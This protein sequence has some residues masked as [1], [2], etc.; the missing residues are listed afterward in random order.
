MRPLSCA[1]FIDDQE[2]QHVVQRGLQSG[3][4]ME[5]ENLRPYTNYTMYIV[6]YNMHGGSDP[7]RKLTVSTAEDGTWTWFSSDPRPLRS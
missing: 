1:V 7:S 6:A 5:L 2:V 4:S 3:G